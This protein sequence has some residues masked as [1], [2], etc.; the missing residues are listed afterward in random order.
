[1]LNFEEENEKN[2]NF[3]S[4]NTDEMKKLLKKLDNQLETNKIKNSLK[5]P[6]DDIDLDFDLNFSNNQSNEN[7]NNKINNNIN[8]NNEKENTNNEP[9][10]ELEDN[11]IFK[12]INIKNNSKLK[13]RKKND[14]INSSM[15]SSQHKINNDISIENSINNNNGEN[16]FNNIRKSI[17]DDK[18]KQKNKLLISSMNNNNNDE[19]N[20]DDNNDN[21]DNSKEEFDFDVNEIVDIQKEEMEKNRTEKINDKNKIGDEEENEKEEDGKLLEEKIEVNMKK[22][23]D[24]NRLEE[25]Q[26]RKILEEEEKKKLLEKEKEE[27]KRR[28]EEE[29]K[30]R[31]EE[32]EEKRRLEE[33]ERKRLEEEEEEKKRRLEEEEEKRRLE[34]EEK[35]KRLE[36]EEEEKRRLEKEEEKRRLEE[37]EKKRRLEEEEEKRRLEEEKERK[38]LEEEERKRL[39]EE[40]EKKRLEEE[41]E[42]KRLEEEEEKRRLKEE[43]EK[44]ALEEEEEKKSLEEEEEKRILEEKKIN[45][46]TEEERKDKGEEKIKKED[47]NKKILNQSSTSEDKSDQNSII[48]PEKIKNCK[49]FSS[50][51]EEQK[52]YITSILKDIKI[53]KSKQKNIIN[54]IDK[55][56]TIKIDLNQKEKTL[57]NLINNFSDKIKNEN[58]EDIEKRKH[59]FINHIYFEGMIETNPLLE[60]IP[61][62]EIS[63]I[64]LLNKIYKEQGLKNIPVIKD[65]FDYEKNIFSPDNLLVS[66]YY[67]PIGKL[68]DLKGFIYKYNF[69]KNL[70][71]II[72]C[73]RAFNYWR[74]IQGDGNSFYRSFMF[75]LIEYYI[76]YNDKDNLEQIISEIISD[77]LIDI[78]KEYNINYNTP[79]IILGLLLKFLSKDEIEKV[80]DIFIKSYLL[81]DGSFDKMLIIY[82]RYISFIYV[83]EV[84]KLTEDEKIQEEREEKIIVKNINKELIKTMNVEPNFFI[85][86]LMPYLFDININVLWIDKDF[87][88]CKDGIINFIDEENVEALPLISLGYF[89][90]SYHKIYS[91]SIIE[92]NDEIEK[93]FNSKLN[94]LTKLTIQI[95]NSKEKCEICNNELFIIFLE[96]KFKICNNCLQKYIG[97]IC[98][99]RNKALNKDNYIGQEYYSRS[100]NLKDNYLLNDYE[101]IEIKEETNII[102]YIQHFASIIC[103]KCKG[104]FDKKNL[105]NLKCKCL[106]CDKCLEDMIL[107]ITNGLKILNAYEKKNLGSIICSSCGNNFSYE[108]AI[109]HLKDIK[110]KDKQ[111]AINR[112]SNFIKTL[113]LVCG[114][115]VRQSDNIN[116]YN[117]SVHNEKE[118]GD[119]KDKNK[120]KENFKSIK[121]YKIIRLRKENEKGKGIDYMDIDHVICNNCYEK[122]KSNIFLNTNADIS[123]TSEIKNKEEIKDKNN[124][125]SQKKKEKKKNKYFVD[126]EEGECFCFICNKKHFFIDKDIKNGGCCSSGCIIN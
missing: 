42:N 13:S 5:L 25:K 41:E 2:N 100:F 28:L 64:D 106:L 30:K 16:E 91:N 8:Y 39:E 82:L 21:N 31:L 19:D 85:I 103:S 37:E 62:C 44:K 50:L 1:M 104:I 112:M 120:K 81:K 38:R 59:H 24:I 95:N 56:P 36:E 52:N 77:K 65:D 40:E 122:S 98:S 6:S 63:H 109:D 107:N 99:F 10:D 67:S 80:Y 32:E 47:D 61:E 43:K 89:Y 22:Q 83:D 58:K 90:S 121:S 105:N 68:E 3:T 17:N 125:N 71:V 72:N 53:F 45:K 73:Y 76:L 123:E 33:E 60:L 115:L 7:K 15:N 57:D 108:D 9:K 119:E 23:N 54:D 88:Q 14:N 11:I 87:L 101:F 49:L 69:E 86:C 110:E 20:Y 93:I 66:E 35:K 92:G 102:N 51:L 96:Q 75:S 46:K 126:F 97:K 118:E 113:C 117:S 116:Q 114:D 29:E 124:K 34:E 55:Y 70:K 18:K 4:K 84:I 94:K 74:S 12:E 79:F 26:E 48:I 27:E 111:K 78:Y